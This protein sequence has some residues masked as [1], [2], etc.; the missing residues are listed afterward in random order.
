MAQPPEVPDTGPPKEDVETLIEEAVGGEEFGPDFMSDMLLF[1]YQEADFLFSGQTIY[2]VLGS[3]KRY[4]IRRLHLVKSQL[5]QRINSYACLL[6]DLLDAVDIR[7]AYDIPGPDTAVE[8]ETDSAS[9]NPSSFADH[10]PDDRCKFCLLAAWADH[11]VLVFEGR[12]VGPSIEL[13]RVENKYAE[14]AHLFPRDFDAIDIDDI[15]A[16]IGIDIS[17]MEAISNEVAYSN[18]QLDLFSIYYRRGRLYEWTNK[19]KLA[20][21]VAELP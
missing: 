3:Y 8:E 19:G 17:D 13:E 6:C 2:L 11:L 18:T 12:H 14:K 21:M 7:Y 1:F 20:V 4:P 16:D 10:T 5:N 9:I 15:Q